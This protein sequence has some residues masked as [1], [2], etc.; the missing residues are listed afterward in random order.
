M[1]KAGKA[2]QL[3][4]EITNFARICFTNVQTTFISVGVTKEGTVKI[5]KIKISKNSYIDFVYLNI[6]YRFCF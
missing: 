5:D 1:R 6:Y 2:S 3:F 4:E